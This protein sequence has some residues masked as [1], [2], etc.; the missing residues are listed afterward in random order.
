MNELA[1]RAAALADLLTLEP[2]AVDVVEATVA[3]CNDLIDAGEPILALDLMG[4]TEAIHPLPAGTKLALLLLR[5]RALRASGKYRVALQMARDCLETQPEVIG[6]SQNDGWML[7]ITAAGCLR[8]LNRVDDAIEELLAVRAEL[9]GRPDSPLLALCMDELAS[10]EIFKGRLVVARGHT[11]EAIVSARRAG[12]RLVEAMGLTNL[13]RIEKFLCRWASAEDALEQV[14]SINQADGL[15][16]HRL[17]ARQLRA[18][19]AWKRGRL[20]EAEKVASLCRDDATA[21]G[22]EVHQWYANQALALVALHRGETDRA[23]ESLGEGTDRDTAHPESRRALLT[24][25][26]IGDTYL[27]QGDAQTAL[28]RYDAVWPLAVALV[29]KGD[30]VAELRR[31][32]AEAYQLL[33]RH[34]DAYLE[35]KEALDHC[36]ELGDRYEEA[37]TY[38]TL[39]QSASALGRP[40]EAKQW[41]DQGFAYYDDIETPYEWGKLWLAYGDWLAAPSA[42]EYAHQGGAIEAYQAARDHFERMGALGMLKH[43]EQ[44][45]GDRTG[46]GS[47]LQTSG[48]SAAT[49]DVRRPPRRPRGSAELDRR[50]AWAKETF[51]LITQNRV[52]LGLLEDVA[53]LA[54]S[55]SPILILGESG[56]GKELV[57]RG[58]HRLSAR[59]GSFMPIN[60]GALPREVIESELFGHVAGAFTGAT[61]DKVGLFEACHQGTVFL[62]E[63]AEMSPDLQSRLL[64]FLET[65]EF[66]RV[67]SNRNVAVDTLVLAATNRDRTALESGDGFRVDLYYRLAHAVVVIPPLRRRGEDLDLLIS[68]LLQEACE[69]QG[70][71][72]SLATSARNRL[73]A[74]SW[75]GNVRQLRSTLNRLV[76]LSPPGH[77]V[78]GNAI[79]LDESQAPANLSEE[80][81]QAERRKIVEALAAASGVRS[82]AA[83]ML[84]MSRTTL[85]GKMQRFGIR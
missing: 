40:A 74:Y 66:R 71:Q 73:I 69:R 24:S 32:R 6:R 82:E 49:A 8:Q 76:I 61:R 11:L 75:P 81:E 80:L 72:V 2:L 57:A 21:L 51:G 85:I 67:G 47:E 12:S 68:H 84:G 48:G 28:E 3:C 59:T 27:E 18:V 60:C 14:I 23:R 35:A 62:D 22:H 30:I 77:E 45:L 17:I 64:R 55:G 42:A 38:R 19:V 78:S 54:R 56:T 29:P 10:A 43:V 33:G 5:V 44:R 37:A 20:N 39:A 70:K 58:I 41:F 13:A 53:K 52:V 1:N 83:K 36:R 26:F 46:R 65:G 34:Q 25:E 7:R 9:T 63:I 50:S 79:E 31:R 15:R 16:I 4:R